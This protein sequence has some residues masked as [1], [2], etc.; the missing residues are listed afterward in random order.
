[1]NLFCFA[2][3]NVE[4]IRR[5][6]DARRWAVSTARDSVMKGRRTKAARYFSPGDYGL[7]YCR[8]T[9]SFTTPFIVESKADPDAV[10]TDIWPEAW[11]LPF[12]ISP[13]GGLER[14]LS[15]DAARI[16]WPI[17]ERRGCGQGGVTAAMNLTGTT[18]FSPI[19]ITEED[20]RLILEDL[21]T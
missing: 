9:H 14:Q 6:I 2:S 12:F 16:R 21:A 18:V 20:W 15:G 5:G 8:P 3:R 11:E 10:V 7:L 1:M 13:L 17:I 4:N 19:P